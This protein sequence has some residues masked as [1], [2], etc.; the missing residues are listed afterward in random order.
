VRDTVRG[1]SGALLVIEMLPVALPAEVGE[2]VAVSDT[3]WP[4]VITC[5]VVMPLTPK[6]APDAVAWEIVTLEV[7]VLESVI[8]WDPTA[9][10]RTLPK[11]ILVEFTDNW[12]TEEG[13]LEAP[14]SLNAAMPPIMLFLEDAVNVADWLPVEPTFLSPTPRSLFALLELTSTVYP[15]AM[16]EI[17]TATSVIPVK[18]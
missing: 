1:E 9:P 15:V 10:T 12:P 11:L 8:A 14:A 6:P 5:G 3:F 2:N 16:L 7:P 13:A 4:A 18:T 17:R